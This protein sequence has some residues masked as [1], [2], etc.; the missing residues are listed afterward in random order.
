MSIPIPPELA[1]EFDHA[2]K[3]KHPPH[4]TLAYLGRPGPGRGAAIRDALRETS[5]AFPPVRIRVGGLDHFVGEDEVGAYA[6]VAAPGIEAMRNSLVANLEARGIPVPTEHGFVPHVT[7]A[8]LPRQ[9]RWAGTIPSGIFTANAV[10]LTSPTGT[11]VFPLGA[12]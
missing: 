2:W 3:G 8:Y 10:E 11:E 9:A 4:I 7:L 12:R 6:K 5:A 1:G